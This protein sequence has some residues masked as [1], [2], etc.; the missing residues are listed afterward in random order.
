MSNVACVKCGV[1]GESKCP[2]CRN[3][4]PD[5]NNNFMLEGLEHRIILREHVTFRVYSGETHESV[6]QGLKRWLSRLSEQDITQLACVHKW[7]FKE[8]HGSLIGCGH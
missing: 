7:E 3:I 8:G 2:H 4:F 1:E 6:L 5:E